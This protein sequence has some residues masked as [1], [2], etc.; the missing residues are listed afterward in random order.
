MGQGTSSRHKTTDL[1]KSES[2][3]VFEPGK[4]LMSPSQQSFDRSADRST[5]ERGNTSFMQLFLCCHR[6]EW[7]GWTV[8]NDG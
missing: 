3:L 2:T 5:F 6:I 7:G 4:K 1:S 8:A